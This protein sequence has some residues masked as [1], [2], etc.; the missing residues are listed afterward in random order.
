[1]KRMQLSAFIAI[2]ALVCS[3]CASIVS[4][5][6]YP[7]TV[8]TTPAGAMIVI[9]NHKG[10]E[11]FSGNSP[12]VVDL[13][14]GAGFFKKASYQVIISKAGYASQ[15]IPV[16]CSVDGWYW[17]NLLLG[18]VV[19]MLIVDPATGA[20]YELDTEEID[21][22]LTAETSSI[23]QPQLQVYDIAS[24]PDSWKDKLV[25]LHP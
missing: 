7:L 23:G 17:G 4:D 22:V 3:S 18:V 11:V 25:R 12:A 6:I 15:T 21:V 20:M 10:K 14:A 1:M 2:V 13:E 19:G 5:T 16:H 9:K 24:I 8:K